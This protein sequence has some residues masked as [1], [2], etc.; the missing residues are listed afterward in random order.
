ESLNREWIEKYFVIEEADRVVFGNPFKEIVEPG[1]Q[2]FFVVVN[3][4]PMGT[5]AVMRLDD[6]VYEIAKMAVSS[7]AHGRGYSNLLMKSAIEFA[8]HAGADKLILL[9][10]TRLK[11]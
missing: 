5:C 11:A 2:I 9:S 8:K 3:G 1:G 4:K 10:N 7:E 6:H